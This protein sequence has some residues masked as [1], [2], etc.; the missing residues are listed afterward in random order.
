MPGHGRIARRLGAVADS[1]ACHF[2]Q[3]QKSGEITIM[4]G[5]YNSTDCRAYTARVWFY[6][7]L[8]GQ[9][10]PLLTSPHDIQNIYVGFLVDSDSRMMTTALAASRTFNTKSTIICIRAIRYIAK[11]PAITSR[12]QSSIELSVFVRFCRTSVPIRRS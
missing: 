6:I 5:H 12:S 1:V 10:R 9:R 7:I 4:A 3:Q 8:L 2:Q 11:P